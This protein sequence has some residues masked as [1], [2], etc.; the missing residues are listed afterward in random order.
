MRRRTPRPVS[1][2]LDSLADRIAPQ[3]LLAAVQREWP[4]VAGA[5]AKVSEPVSER[6]GIVTVACD[7]AVWAQELELMGEVVLAR[8]NAALGR[9]A[10]LRLRTRPTRT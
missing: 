10:V 8:L 9:P 3:T 5:F 2:A 1:F 7:S 4:N 6:D